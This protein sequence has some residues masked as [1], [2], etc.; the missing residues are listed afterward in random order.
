MFAMLLAKDH[1]FAIRR[2]SE[3]EAKIVAARHLTT[4]EFE[5]WAPDA[6]KEE[7][8]AWMRDHQA[9]L[10]TDNPEDQYEPGTM[11]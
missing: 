2:A 11:G 1:G 8:E 10:L 4:M 9:E 7:Y 5:I 3:R 6:S